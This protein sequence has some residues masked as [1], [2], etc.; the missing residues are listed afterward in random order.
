MN[1]TLEIMV[2]RMKREFNVEANVGVSQ[3]SYRETIKGT[4]VD[5]DFKYV[6][7]S[8]GEGPIRSRSNYNQN[9]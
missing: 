8:G 6:K 9:L 2:D 7:Q 4:C 3:V 1:F 5:E